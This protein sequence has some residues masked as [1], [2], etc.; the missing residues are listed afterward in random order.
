MIKTSFMKNNLFLILA[1]FL[2]TNIYSQDSI[3]NYL[4]S[5]GKIVEKEYATQLETLVKKDTLWQVT[6]YLGNG[7]VYLSGHYKNIDKKQHIG[8][9]IT[10]H[11]NGQV[12]S[13]LFY[14]NQ[15]KKNGRYQAWFANG[16][17]SGNGIYLTGK[18]ESIWKYYHYNGIEAS[19]IY[20]KNDSILK[21]MIFDDEGKK[22]NVDLIKNNK[23]KFKEGIERFNSE[24]KKLTKDIGYQIKGNIHVYFVVGV[25]GEIRDV[26]INE[27]LPEELNQHI[28]SFFEDIVGWKPAIHMNRKI[29]SSFTVPLKFNAR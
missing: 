7:K 4:D 11:I 3:V 25:N 14:N 23:P 20:Y 13:L 22:L 9:L 17:L 18:K 5:K 28:V 26:T 16:K 27:E 2:I 1:L 19:R 6:R 10:Y 8:E 15:G 29:P 21:A 24:V 12:A